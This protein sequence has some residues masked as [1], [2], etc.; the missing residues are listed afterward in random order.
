MLG[1]ALARP[2]KAHVK[3]YIADRFEVSQDAPADA[4]DRISQHFATRGG[5][6]FGQAFSYVQ[7]VRDGTRSFTNITKCFFNDF[8]RANGAPEVTPIFCALDSVWAAEVADARYGVRF[9]RPT[10]LALG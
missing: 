5:E 10:T 7:E 9:E 6:R 3:E 2:L 1:D 4:F 8:F